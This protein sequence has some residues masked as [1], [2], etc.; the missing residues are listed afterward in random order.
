MTTRLLDQLRAAWKERRKEVDDQFSRTL[1]LGEY[2]VDRWEKATA[3]GFGTGASI[4]DSA[5][6][7]GDVSVAE[8]TWI[9]PFVILDG[10]GGLRI[11][12]NCSI[13]AGVHVYSHDTVAWAVSG[14]KEK[15]EYGETRIGNNCY[16]GPNTIVT[17]GVSIGDG[18]IIGA[19]SVVTKDVPANS[20]AFGSPCR[21]VGVVTESNGVA[22][23]S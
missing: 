9:G 8:D 1:S 17:K 11:G 10:T 7:F 21:V 18:C 3:L 16:I 5:L 22:G 23:G 15:Y 14:G 6:V 2:V 4:Y 13:S 12:R 20:K 19:N